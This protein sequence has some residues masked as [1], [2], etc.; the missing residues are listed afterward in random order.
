[1]TDFFLYSKCSLFNKNISKDAYNT[2][3]PLIPSESEI[4]Y[5]SHTNREVYNKEKTEEFAGD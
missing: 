3:P 4:K 2:P 5:S 1:M